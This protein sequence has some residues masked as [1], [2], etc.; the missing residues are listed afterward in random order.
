MR[1]PG[2]ISVSDDALRKVL[3]SA[4]RSF[5][6]HGFRDIVFIGDHGDYQNLMQAVATTL[7]REWLKSRT[8]IAARAH[9]VEE[10]Y[11]ASS[12]GYAQLLKERGFRDD[13][14]GIH[15]GLADTSLS[16]AVDPN[17][18]RAERMALP[19]TPADGV[20]GDPRRASAELG[21]LGIELIVNKTV[22]AIHKA[23]QR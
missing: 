15:A 16:L 23:I 10:Y 6:Q 13:E 17:L 22:A 11:R 18:V 3:E 21:R 4:A 1:F 9:A 5:R 2:T 7:N 14:I 8:P 19:V 20:R 12:S